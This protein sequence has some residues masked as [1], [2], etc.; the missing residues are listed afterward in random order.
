MTRPKKDGGGRH[1]PKRGTDDR[2]GQPTGLPDLPQ[3]DT[4]AFE[5]AIIDSTIPVSE[6]G[7]EEL[8]PEGLG[9][10]GVGDHN[11][12]ESLVAG[13]HQS[14]EH[15]TG[16]FLEEASAAAWMLHD[17]VPEPERPEML[18][19]FASLE[20][21]GDALLA[22]L[23]VV[24]MS[25]EV[26]QNARVSVA[27]KQGGLPHWLRDLSQASIT[28]CAI[29]RFEPDDEV[30]V[31]AEITIPATEPF[32]V[33]IDRAKIV[34]ELIV[35][36]ATLPE[37]LDYLMADGDGESGDD[38]GRGGVRIEP[39]DPQGLANELAISLTPTIEWALSPESGGL[40]VDTGVEAMLPLAHW[41]STLLPEPTVEP[42][43]GYE[44]EQRDHGLAIYRSEA[45]S[46]PSEADLRLIGQALDF[47][48]EQDPFRW[49]PQRLI[50]MF[51][52]ISIVVHDPEPLLG[53]LRRFLP[54]AAAKQP[55]GAELLEHNLTV[56]DK[57]EEHADELF[58]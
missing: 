8:G 22:A 32:L 23:A 55:N 45:A 13:L 19:M 17:V 50:Y 30:E 5:Q 2:G 6:L 29:G 42:F 35:D 52:R 27:L 12:I 54:F 9:P 40:P 4:D 14:L 46:E 58:A 51:E 43:F 31:I 47:S 26:R 36:I 37:R 1:T 33:V 57:V 34:H 20:G 3:L 25:T 56:L 24:G 11:P 10:E 44:G 28:G 16:S 48:V 38:E 53:A 7:S 41:V 21:T 15:G 18:S 49:T 39:T